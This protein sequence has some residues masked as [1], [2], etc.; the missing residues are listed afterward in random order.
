MVSHSSHMSSALSLVP[1]RAIDGYRVS[2]LVLAA[3]AP[4]GRSL[5]QPRSTPPVGLPNTIAAPTPPS[6]AIATEPQGASSAAAPTTPA[7]VE[8]LGGHHL[9][10]SRT[11]QKLAVTEYVAC[12]LPGPSPCQRSRPT[13]RVVDPRH[14]EVGEVVAGAVAAFGFRADGETLVVLKSDGA[15]LVDW[16]TKTHTGRPSDF[17]PAARGAR[18]ICLSP[19][20]DH[21]LAVDAD[22]GARLMSRARGEP[23]FIAASGAIKDCAFSP[24]GRRFAVATDTGLE[25]FDVGAMQAAS[26][27]SFP[28]ITHVAWSTVDS[29]VSFSHVDDRGFQ[30][31]VGW[32]IQHSAGTIQ[33]T[34]GVAALDVPR[35][36]VVA[37]DSCAWHVTTFDGH[38]VPTP[39]APAARDACFHVHVHDVVVAPNGAFVAAAE[40]EWGGSNLVVRALP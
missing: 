13:V 34:S 8:S 2:L 7:A 30:L 12:G 32:A 5:E 23:L 16:S 25:I 37:R 17:E 6:T 15:G 9:F 36:H 19:D 33:Q 38:D 21:L 22:G 28:E 11:S 1:S 35:R 3:C 18:A 40:G 26:V 39:V 14:P 31:F 20:D 10:W 24:T 29:W 4:V 27:V